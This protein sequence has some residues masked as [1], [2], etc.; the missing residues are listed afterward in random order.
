MHMDVQKDA[1][2]VLSRGCIWMCVSVCLYDRYVCAR[3]GRCFYI[4][5]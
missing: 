1:R 5:V 3:A 2:V 4:F